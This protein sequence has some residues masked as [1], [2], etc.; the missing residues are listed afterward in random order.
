MYDNLCVFILRSAQSIRV[1][2]LKLLCVIF[3]GFWV[4]VEVFQRFSYV[5]GEMD[6]GAEVGVKVFV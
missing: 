6:E 1:S 4:R 2:L 5:A 3:E